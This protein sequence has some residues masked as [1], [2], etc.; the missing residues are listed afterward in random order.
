AS[1][2]ACVS[3]Y[4]TGSIANLITVHNGYVSIY[5][6]N[7][8]SAVIT[9]SGDLRIAGTTTSLTAAQRVLTRSYYNQVRN[10]VHQGIATGKAGGA[11]A[12][13]VIGAVITGLASGDTNRIDRTAN[14]QATKIEASV[15]TICDNLQ[16]IRNIQQQITA[17]IPAFAPYS[18]IDQQRVIDYRSGTHHP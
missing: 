11:M 6:N 8:S 2:G 9:A 12:S 1:L 16:A 4:S 7:A 5:G 18:V 15:A 10:I 17:Q 3:A 14:L 13:K